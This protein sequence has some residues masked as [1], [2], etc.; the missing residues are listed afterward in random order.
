VARCSRAVPVREMRKPAFVLWQVRNSN[1][2]QNDYIMVTTCRS[3]RYRLSDVLCGTFTKLNTHTHT[4]PTSAKQKAH[5]GFEHR[6]HERCVHSPVGLLVGEDARV[7]RHQRP[8]EGGRAVHVLGSVL[9][10]ALALV[11]VHRGVDRD[12]LQGRDNATA[13]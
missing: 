11:L 8:V 1:T 13:D 10:V 7:G 12:G 9:E 2:G 4:S 6:L 5:I 3:G